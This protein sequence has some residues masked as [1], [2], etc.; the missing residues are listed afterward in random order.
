MEE[1]E[2]TGKVLL[3]RW[4]GKTGGGLEGVFQGMRWRSRS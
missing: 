1:E 3:R 2:K 4:R